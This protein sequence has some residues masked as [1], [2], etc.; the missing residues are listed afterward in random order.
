MVASTTNHPSADPK[1]EQPLD[2][3]HP[4][5]KEGIAEF[6]SPNRR[7][8]HGHADSRLKEQQKNNLTTS[9]FIH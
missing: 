4:P 9:A 6:D 1:K 7:A 5:A 8:R 2:L 3:L